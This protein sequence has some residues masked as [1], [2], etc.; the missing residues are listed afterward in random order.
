MTERAVVDLHVFFLYGRFVIFTGISSLKGVWDKPMFLD[1]PL[2]SIFYRR[3]IGRCVCLI[4]Q[5][6]GAKVFDAL[7]PA[8]VSRRNFVAISCRTA[9]ETTTPTK[10]T[11]SGLA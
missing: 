2:L 5:A 1:L 4:R 10:L 8:T 7:C 3:Y 9:A 11:V 6:A